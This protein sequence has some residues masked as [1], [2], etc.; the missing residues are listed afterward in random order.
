MKVYRLLGEMSANRYP[1]RPLATIL[2]AVADP[3]PGTLLKECF[4]VYFVLEPS[5]HLNDGGLWWWLRIIP[6]QVPA[7]HIMRLRLEREMNQYEHEYHEV[8][9]FVIRKVILGLRNA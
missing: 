2:A 6:S 7:R 9:H 4:G 5:V 3:G 8:I 1:L